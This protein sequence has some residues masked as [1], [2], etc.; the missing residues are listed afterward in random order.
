[1][2]AYLDLKARK[3]NGEEVD[4]R[5]I[6]KHKNDVLRIT[7]EFLLT[8]ISVLPESVYMDVRKFFE[9]LAEE[10]FD[11]SLL[12]NYG[13]SNMELVERLQEIYFL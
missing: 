7:S 9:K 10:P 3:E 11:A 8:H 6:K 4:S 12:Q 13:L 5:N 1:M 2:K